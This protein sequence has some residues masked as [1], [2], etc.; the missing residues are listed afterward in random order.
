MFFFSF[1]PTNFVTSTARVTGNVINSLRDLALKAVQKAFNALSAANK[2]LTEKVKILS[3]KKADHDSPIFSV[4]VIK[5]DE[6]CKH[7]TGFPNYSV[8]VSVLNL[9][10]PGNNGENVRLVSAPNS[11]L[12]TGCGR[13][14][15]LT[16]EQQFLLTLMTIRRGFSTEHLGWLFGIDKSTVSRLFV[17]WVNFMYLS[18][19]YLANKRTGRCNY[20]TEFQRQL[21]KD[22]CYYRLY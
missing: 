8:F 16:G 7:Y 18:N 1:S 13:K 10:Q 5:S 9:L 2:Q 19:S 6:K 12:E 21:P 17:S 20:A 22:T 3:R 15:S 11:R 4:D 14:R